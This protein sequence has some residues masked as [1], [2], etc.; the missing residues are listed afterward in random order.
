M[1][2]ELSRG[3]LLPYAM[4]LATPTMQQATGM[5]IKLAETRN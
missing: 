4:N 3:V 5:W 1:N 2:Q